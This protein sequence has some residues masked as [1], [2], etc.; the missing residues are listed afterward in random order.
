MRISEL[1]KN[2]FK[3]KSRGKMRK[4]RKLRFTVATFV[5]FQLLSL[6]AIAEQAASPEQIADS[7]IRKAL[8]NGASSATVAIM[9]AGGIVYAQAF[10]MRDKSKSIPVDTKT[11][12]NIGSCSKI[13]T[14]A[15]ILMLCE[16]KKVNL[17]KPVTAYLTDFKMADPR[18]RDITVRM[19]LN[20][21]SGMPGSNAK[22]IFG[23]AE[24]RKYVS[25]TL[26]VLDESSLKANPGEIS[27]YCN[28]GFTVA[29][30]LIEKISG[31]SYSDFLQER[32]FNKAGMKN[33]SCYFKEGNDNIA[34]HY[35]NTGAQPD[36]TEYVNALAS[37]G[38][39]STAID[40]CRFAH[41]VWSG[42]LFSEKYLEEYSKEQYG[43]QTALSGKP[44]FKFGLGWDTVSDDEFAKQDITALA[45]AG[46]TSQFHS[47][48]LTAPAKKL[49]VAIIACGSA[50]VGK[51]ASKIMQ[52]LLEEKGYIQP[53]LK[54]S[55][56]VLAG[57]AIPDVMMRFEG[58]YRYQDGNS[59]YKAVFDKTKNTVSFFRFEDGKFVDPGETGEFH[60]MSDSYFHA[61]SY[62]FKFVEKD[63]N[64][65]IVA[66]PDGSQDGFVEKQMLLLPEKPFSSAKFENKF[67]LSKNLSYYDF[68]DSDAAVKSSAIKEM[69]GYIAIDDNICRLTGETKATSALPYCRDAKEVS[70]IE[71][72]GDQVLKILAYLYSDSKYTALLQAGETVIIGKEGYNEWRIAGKDL[73]LDCSVPKKSRIL[74][75]SAEG[76]TRYDSLVYGV[77]PFEVKRGDFVGFIGQPG[78]KF[79]L[80]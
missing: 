65:Y 2:N 68:A 35:S 39:S 60:F 26:S 10:G 22:D 19:L 6:I 73:T 34:C 29:E 44:K 46:D 38:I 57:A 17:D 50:D 49:T 54:E 42:K 15:A 40:L 67:W 30:A 59:S 13:F 16:D 8:S 52:A 24:N 7:E 71:K 53:K 72:N 43:S 41:C 31:M 33:T 78:G 11:Q 56:T 76:K 80:R 69:P 14:A 25:E 61:P 3:I 4:T 70:L 18:Y 45:K 47:Y 63:K 20:H 79:V 23:N 27:V 75:I 55:S 37:G 48:L 9:D 74:V 12:F 1:I 66:Y 32:I 51:I 5:V 77:N 64:K 62:A 28:D 58:I 36:P 21:T